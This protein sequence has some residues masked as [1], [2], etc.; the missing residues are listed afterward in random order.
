M[1][2]LSVRRSSPQGFT[3][4]ELLVV[5]V[6]IGGMLAIAIPLLRPVSYAPQNADA[7]RRLYMASLAQGIQ[8]YK[9]QNGS[10]PPGIPGVDTAISS[11]SNG[12]NLCTYLVPHYLKDIIIDASAGL[13][14]TG[15]ETAPEPTDEG[16]DKPGVK[17]VSGFAIRQAKDGAVTV[18][19]AS[20]QK[21]GAKLELTIR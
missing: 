14:Y 2:K 20:A 12:Y 3:I 10:F 15:D 19:G 16:C 4:P 5:I 11:Q 6:I 7:T 1:Q 13:I 21:S 17:Y 9:T 18:V 8:R